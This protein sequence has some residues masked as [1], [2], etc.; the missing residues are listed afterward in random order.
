[1]DRLQL[2]IEKKQRLDGFRP[3]ADAFLTGM[4]DWLKIELTYTSNA[5]EGNTLSRAQT[6]MIVEKGLT[7]EGKSIREHQE[8]VN[9]ASAFEWMMDE[10]RRTNFHID[11]PLI[12]DIHR[13]ILAKIDDS[14]AGRY[15]TVSV[16]IAGSR[17]IMPNAAKVP[18]FMESFTRW[19]NTERSHPVQKAIDAHLKLVSIHPFTDGNGRTARL[20]MNALLLVSGYLPAIVR[21]EDRLAYINAIEK[22]QLGGSSNDY[23]AV[24]YK[25]VERTMDAYLD[26]LTES[27]GDAQLKKKTFLKIGDVARLAGE[28]VPTIRHWTQLGLLDVS[29]FT[30]GGYQLFSQEAVTV[31]RKIR[32]LQT[33]KRMTLSEIKRRIS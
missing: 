8:V 25:A 14:N 31:A 22:V 6:A 24:M 23:Y 29:E 9:H 27:S 18:Q 30:P 1:M 17:V 2:I 4:Q 15:R 7:V 3:F 19:C 5:I 21:K 20:V 13:R 11:E 33:E 10:I 26:M 28:P 32:R 12:L 16:R